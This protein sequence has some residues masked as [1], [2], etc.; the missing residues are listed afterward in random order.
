MCCSAVDGR[1]LCLAALQLCAYTAASGQDHN[2]DA[3]ASRKTQCWVSKCLGVSLPRATGGAQPL[4]ES[5]FQ[6]QHML[7]S[8]YQQP[9]QTETSP[10]AY[11][12][13]ISRGGSTT[14]T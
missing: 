12:G 14:L 10:S 8:G 3:P 11:G 13:C 6:D 1:V 2:A 4:Q 9:N 5:Q 7:H